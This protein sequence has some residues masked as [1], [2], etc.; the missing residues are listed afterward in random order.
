[1]RCVIACSGGTILSTVTSPESSYFSLSYD[2]MLLGRI[3]YVFAY[4][5]I[6]TSIQCLKLGVHPAPGAHIFAAWCTFFGGVHQV[7]ERFLSS[8]HYYILGGCMGGFPG[9]QFWE[10]CTL[11]VHKIKP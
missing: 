9:A 6:D 11:W 10:K 7:C 8:Y 2:V 1:M 5:M 3:N 4:K